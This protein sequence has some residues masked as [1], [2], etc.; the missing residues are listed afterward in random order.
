LLREDHL[1]Q[2]VQLLRWKLLPSSKHT[3]EKFSEMTHIV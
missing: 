3:Q 1:Y 2:V